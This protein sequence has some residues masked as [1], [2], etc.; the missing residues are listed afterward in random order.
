V[1]TTLVFPRGI[2][3]LLQQARWTRLHAPA[4]VPAGERV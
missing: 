4:A 1:L 3:G 2:V